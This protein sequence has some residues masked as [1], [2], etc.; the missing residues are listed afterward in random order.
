MTY[1]VE[2][3]ERGARDTHQVI[4]TAAS[5]AEAYRKAVAQSGMSGLPNA[6][7]TPLTHDW[8]DADR[9]WC[10]QPKGAR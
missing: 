1:R 3:T 10:N 4:V 8:A 6:V 2:L 7:I 5:Q 9:C